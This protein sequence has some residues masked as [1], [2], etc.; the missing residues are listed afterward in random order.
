M[1]SKKQ[2]SF[3]DP[4][5]PQGPI[6]LNAYYLP[7]SV[8][9]LW[10]YCDQFPEISQQFTLGDF[11]WRRDPI[12]EVV[13]KLKHNDIVGF[14]VYIWNSSYS[15]LL[16]EALKKANPDI[17]IIWGGPEPPIEKADI[18]QR[19]PYVD[20]VVKTEGEIS[21]KRI[22]ENFEHKEFSHIPGLLLNKDCEPVDTGLAERITDVNVI[23]SPYLSGY[24]DDLMQSH[25]EILWT[26]IFE[27]NRG[28]PYQCTFCDWGSL[29]YT[30]IKKFDIERVYAELEWFG[31]NR[32][33]YI[34][35]TDANF[36]IFPERDLGIA[37][38]LIS[39]Q[40]QYDNPK[41]YTISWAKN[42]K[43]EVINIVKTLMNAG[44]NA[45]L[46]V[47]VQSMDDETLTAIKRKNLSMNQI[48]EVFDECELNSIPL[49]TEL[50]LG[51]PA[52]TLDNWRENFYKL[53][54]AGNHTGVS[55]YQ[56]QLLENAE[57]NLTQRN[58]Y[59]IEG[60]TVYDYLM[61][62]ETDVSGILEGVEIVVSTLDLPK[63]KMIQAQMFSWF[64]NTF[65]INGLTTYV[66]RFL[67]KH[68]GIEY[69]DFYSELWDFILQDEW[70]KSEF[71]RVQSCYESWLNTGKLPANQNIENIEIHGWN[72]IHSS[73]IKLHSDQK[74]AHVSSV[75][76]K[77]VEHHYSNVVDANVLDQLMDFQS[78]YIL[79]H[80]KLNEYPLVKQFDYDFLNYIQDKGDLDVPS[81]YEF[82]FR[83]DPS[84][85][86]RT[87]CQKIWFDRRKNFGK[88]WIKKL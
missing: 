77:F 11:I 28:C 36:G 73:L 42:Q 13:E 76:R 22:L 57:M 62:S 72:L 53:Y 37:K 6:E 69:K 16:A 40:E 20:I 27:T 87:F 59:C 9:L 3:V 50:I 86:L 5:Y 60:L 65:H 49:F 64:Q 78:L 47:S 17:F 81:T 45:G 33:D 85:T 4:N 46:N 68:A 23:P 35:I 80:S 58:L 44:N 26:G 15:S 55:V 71:D 25:P 82:E 1:A 24:F 84:M 43:S 83:D 34:A 41:N 79:D 70:I 19:H 75:L 7:Y 29:T 52:Q 14:S 48:E 54:E 61:N 12:D 32:I 31:K 30:K 10:A 56:A 63:P 21:F 67:K 74:G 66:C 51:L 18:F 2:I 38:K 8:G 39:V 88:A